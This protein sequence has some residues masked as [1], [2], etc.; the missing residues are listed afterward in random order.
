MNKYT[1]ITFES[2]HFA[3]K[4]ESILGESD[5]SI[6]LITTPRSVTSRCGFSLEVKEG[7]ESVALKLNEL[8]LKY[9]ILY[10]LEIVDGVKYYAKKD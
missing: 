9:D 3:L 1:I 6:S 2:V 10:E 8:N 5:L 7:A 4:C